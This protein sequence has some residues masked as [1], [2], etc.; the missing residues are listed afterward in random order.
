MQLAREHQIKRTFWR[1]A[2]LY[3]LLTLPQAVHQKPPREIE[4]ER[5]QTCSLHAVL[6]L[7]T[8]PRRRHSEE[9]YAGTGACSLQR[10]SNKHAGN[11]GSAR[12]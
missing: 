3:K 7:R 8:S 10:H 5:S 6:H 9:E 1:S 2:F 11:E 4:Q 12:V